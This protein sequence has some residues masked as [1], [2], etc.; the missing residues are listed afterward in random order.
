MGPSL[1]VLPIVQK[2]SLRS[3]SILVAI[4][5]C[6][7][8][9]QAT[10]A[11][12]AETRPPFPLI[13]EHPE[14]AEVQHGPEDVV[15]DREAL[16]EEGVVSVFPGQTVCLDLELE[17]GF[18]IPRVAS[19]QSAHSL[20][21]TMTSRAAPESTLLRVFNP[22]SMVLKYRAGMSLPDEGG[23][24]E[25]SSCGVIPGGS[26]LEMWSHPIDEIILGNL[27]FLENTGSVRCE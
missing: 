9:A 1:A 6:V 23:Y 4:A 2:R 24:Y 22:Y 27:H 26:A 20:V 7:A 21:L 3:F 14:L 16:I 10:P 19:V 11:P 12:P 17:G 8:C 13:F 15:C 5:L 25:T 18:V